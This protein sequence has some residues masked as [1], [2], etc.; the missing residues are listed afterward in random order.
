MHVSVM[1]SARV[2]TILD[3]SIRHDPS[4]T[5]MSPGELLRFIQFLEARNVAASSL[6]WL[7]D[8]PSERRLSTEYVNESDDDEFDVVH[9]AGYGDGE[10]GDEDTRNQMNINGARTEQWDYVEDLIRRFISAAEIYASDRGQRNDIAR[11]LSGASLASIDALP[12]VSIQKEDMMNRSS[13]CVVCKDDFKLNELV[14]QLPCLHLYHRACIR[15]WLVVR[16]SC[17]L[18]RFQ[19]PAEV[20]GLQTSKRHRS[21]NLT[22]SINHISSTESTD[23]DEATPM[24][25]ISHIAESDHV[26]ADDINTLDDQINS[27][28]HRSLVEMVSAWPLYSV[29][30]LTVIS[31]LG[32]L[33]LGSTNSLGHIVGLQ[34]NFLSLANCRYYKSLWMRVFSRH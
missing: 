7:S 32:N 16:N 18:C 4:D 28:R 23:L 27:S 15:P 19:L 25:Q 11:D 6:S 3:A 29:M 2:L 9:N 12:L 1:D 31:C 13:L 10:D 5:D 22:G 24:V 20:L 30:G 26:E 21:V 17:P 8:A 33:L 14:Q 34:V